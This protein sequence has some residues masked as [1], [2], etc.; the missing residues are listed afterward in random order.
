MK[1]KPEDSQLST[2]SDDSI[3]VRGNVRPRPV[4]SRIIS[5]GFRAKMRINVGEICEAATN[6]RRLSEEGSCAI[7]SSQR[8]TFLPIL[9]YLHRVCKDIKRNHV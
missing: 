6:R 7:L 2:L 4:L 9:R 5:G 1:E 3:I 8:A